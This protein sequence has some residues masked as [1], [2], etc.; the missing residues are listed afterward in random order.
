MCLHLDIGA[1]QAHPKAFGFGH[2]D[3]IGALTGLEQP[4]AK[5]TEMNSVI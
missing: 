5:Q 2:G 1:D 4:H 3:N